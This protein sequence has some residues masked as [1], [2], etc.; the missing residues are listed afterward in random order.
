VANDNKHLFFYTETADA[1]TKPSGSNWMR[2]YIDWDKNANTGWNGYDY[3]IVKGSEL[4]RYSNG[5][6]MAIGK[7][8]VKPVINKNRMML[9]IPLAL[10]GKLSGPPE[11]DFKWTDNM[12]EED[13]LDWYINGDAAPGARFNYQYTAK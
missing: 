13:P 11:F 7:K 3:R 10:F 12:Q 5:K 8:A 6:W 9:T 1:I 2:L 4:Q